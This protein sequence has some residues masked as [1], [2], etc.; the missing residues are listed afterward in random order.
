M[1]VSGCPV[2]LD[3][4][5]LLLACGSV[6]DKCLGYARE[7]DGLVGVWGGTTERERKAIQRNSLAYRLGMDYL[8]VAH[9]PTLITL[10]RA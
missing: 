1:C 9:D 8:L 5:A 7:H 10:A 4:L 3:C 6:A 2:T